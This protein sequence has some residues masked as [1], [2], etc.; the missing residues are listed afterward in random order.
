MDIFLL[1]HF[2]SIKNTQVTF[3]SIDDKEELTENGVIQGKQVSDNL[4]QILELKGLT[5]KNIYCA[6]SVRALQSAEIMASA[7]SESV[8][9]QAFSE[10][11]STKSKD[12]LGK[13]KK[14]VRESNPEFMRQLSLY[15]AGIYS[16][17]DFHR[18][19]GRDLKIEYE[20]KVCKCIEKIVNN[21]AEEDVKI[22]CL[23]NSSLTA[24]VINFA[25]KLCQYPKNHYGKVIADN[26][27][28]FWIHEENNEQK[29]IVAN[30]DSE[31]LLE[32]IRG[33]M[34]VT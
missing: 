30:Y 3:S 32:I 6:E 19:V 21:D 23:H 4:R 25:R 5:V 8:Q 34:Y 31:L 13:T 18:E 22:I 9:V 2:E 20:K 27:K 12:I 29:F 11:L 28:I 14:Q 15:D 26:G 24:A 33:E 17:Y 16:S 1:R 10:L 7:L